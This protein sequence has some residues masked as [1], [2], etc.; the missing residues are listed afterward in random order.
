MAKGKTCPQSNCGYLML[1]IHEDAQ[2]HGSWVTYR[3]RSC[4]FELRVFEKK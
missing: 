3:C 2:A 1:A 4:G